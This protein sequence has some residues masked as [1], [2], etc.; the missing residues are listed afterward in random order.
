MI[1]INYDLNPKKSILYISAILYDFL[2]NKCKDFEE[3]RK[4]FIT[5]I[6]NNELLFYYSMDWLFL[7]GKIIS[8]E[9]GKVKCV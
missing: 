7:T 6:D 4:F 2:K 3:S 1:V 5:N 9:E 8:I